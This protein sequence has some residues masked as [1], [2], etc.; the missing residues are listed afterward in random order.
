ME[1]ESPIPVTAHI[2][3]WMSRLEFSMK[4]SVSKQI[5]KCWH[6]YIYETFEEW[7]GNWP[8]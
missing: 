4:H 2:E 7:I 5:L 1:M 6:A 8:T 3:D